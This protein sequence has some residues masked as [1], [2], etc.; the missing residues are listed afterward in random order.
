[1]HLFFKRI[2]TSAQAPLGGKY[3]EVLMESWS[4]SW[5]PYSTRR[6]WWYENTWHP[7]W[8]YWEVGVPIL[9]RI[10]CHTHLLCGMI[11]RKL[12]RVQM[13]WQSHFVCLSNNLAYWF[14]G[15]T[16]K[17]YNFCNIN[18]YFIDQIS[19]QSF[20]KLIACLLNRTEGNIFY[21]TIYL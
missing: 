13:W 12:S 18:S 8:S 2:R 20:L 5:E 6:G 16:Y 4:P 9:V 19:E 7:A 3:D 1:M 15:E 21:Q 14:E 10:W 17:W 11:P